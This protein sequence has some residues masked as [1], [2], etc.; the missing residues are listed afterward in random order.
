[1]KCHVAFFFA[2]VYEIFRLLILFPR[3]TGRVVCRLGSDLEC[4]ASQCCTI[5]R[6][7]VIYFFFTNICQNF[8]RYQPFYLSSD[9]HNLFCA[10]SVTPVGSSQFFSHFLILGYLLFPVSFTVTDNLNEDFNLSP[11]LKFRDKGYFLG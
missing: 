9:K 5:L 11:V 1:M 4:Y 10:C 2:A 3:Q 6:R 8:S 7:Y